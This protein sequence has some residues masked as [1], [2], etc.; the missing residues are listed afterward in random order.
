MSSESPDIWA[1]ADLATPF[2]VRTAATLRVPDVVKDGPLPLA[3]IAKRCKAVADPLGRVLR[4]LVHRGM[5]TEPEPDVFGP[6]DASN[7]L[8]SDVLDGPRPWLD[9]DGAVGRADLAF[10]ELIEQVRGHHPAYPAAFGRSFWED[11]AHNP[12]LSDS[13]DTLMETKTHGIAPLVAAAHDWSR[14]RRIADIGGGK[15]VLL[16]EILRSGPELRGVLVDLI[17]PTRNAIAY[18]QE[19]EVS[20]RAE[21]VAASFFEPLPVRAD[22]MIICDV[23]GDWDDEDAAQILR[24]CGQALEPGG[25]VLIV[26]LL[27]DD[28]R[29]PTFTE[30]DLRMMVYVGGR[31]RDLDRTQQVAAAAG[32]SVED[33]TMLDNGYAIIECR[34]ER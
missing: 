11:L 14:Y 16:A 13:F 20:D 34:C 21:V 12:Q 17:G 25:R 19:R 15:G 6:N 28:D 22:A 27:P 9:L 30:M 10:V 23:L 31:M 8:L 29:M 3:E 7:A 33:F 26:E 32:L 1:M 24:H 2:A 18:L 4:F 5:F